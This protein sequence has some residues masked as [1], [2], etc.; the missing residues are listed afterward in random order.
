MMIQ[1]EKINVAT[2]PIPLNIQYVS[3]ID[4]PGPRPRPRP[5]QTPAI[6]P[7]PGPGPGPGK[8][9]MKPGF[10]PGFTKLKELFN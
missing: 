9:L 4:R 1:K 3:T 7:N 10:L 6:F 8:N 2:L 5:R